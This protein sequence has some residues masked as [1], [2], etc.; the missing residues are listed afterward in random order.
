MMGLDTGSCNDRFMSWDCID[1]HGAQDYQGRWQIGF[2]QVGSNTGGAVTVQRYES[3]IAQKSRKLET[4]NSSSRGPSWYAQSSPDMNLDDIRRVAITALFSDDKLMQ[5]LV[6]KG[7]TALSLVYQLSLRASLDVDFSLE[8]DFED[9][10]EARARIFH[11]LKNRFDSEGYVV[12]DEKFEPKPRLD[13]EDRKPWWGGYE[14]RFKLIEKDK[15]ARLKNRPDKMRIDATVV[16]PSELRTFTIDLSK[17]EYTVGKVEHELDY[18]TIYVYSPE[19]IVVE[20]LRAICQQ[21][22]EYIHKVRGQARARD[23]YDI[24]RVMTRRTM[25]LTTMPSTELIRQMFAAKRVPVALLARLPEQRE[26]HRPDWPDVQTAVAEKLHEFD[27]Y[28]DFVVTEVE[29]LKPLWH[30]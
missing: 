23:F 30:E 4:I 5:K 8:S 29:R 1:A 22:P 15:H 11:V 27:F 6:L 14:L 16:G 20:K 19:M 2:A 10:E 24:H 28:F 25:D 9:L 12:F 21:M 26:F 7:G 3:P 13:G 17:Y 18:Y